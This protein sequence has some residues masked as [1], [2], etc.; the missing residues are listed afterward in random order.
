MHSFILRKKPVVNF[1][2]RYFFC[3]F[4]V[5][6]IYL[7]SIQF[8][9]KFSKPS[10]KSL[11]PIFISDI[12][13]SDRVNTVNVIEDTL[14]RD[15]VWSFGNIE[16]ICA[17][18]AECIQDNIENSNK[19]QS[20]VGDTIFNH[21]YLD[22]GNMETST[23]DDCNK[24][25]LKG[26]SKDYRSMVDASQRLRLIMFITTAFSY[27]IAKSNKFEYIDLSFL[28][29]QNGEY[30]LTEVGDD[31][32]KIFYDK[33]ENTPISSLS[34]EIKPKEALKSKYFKDENSERDYFAVFSLVVDII[35]ESIVGT[36]D[37]KDS[38][39]IFLN[40]VYLYHEEIDEE[41]KFNR[42]VDRNKKGTP[43]SD[44]SMYP[45]YIIN[46]YNEEEKEKVFRTF[47][48]FK[49]I[50][51]E[52]QSVK[53]FRKTKGGVGALLYIM[54][55]AL[56]IKI[57]E[58]SLINSSIELKKVFSSTFNLSDSEYGIDKCF[59]KG[60]VFRTSEDAIKYFE[61]CIS[62][63]KFLI[64]DSFTNHNDLT[65]DFYYF[66]DFAKEDLMWWYFIKP[67]YITY[68]RFPSNEKKVIFIKNLLF[69]LYE[70]YIVHRS[71][72]S[73]SQNLINLLEKL[74]STF[75]TYNVSDEEFEKT[76]KTLVMSYIENAGGWDGLIATVDSLN[77]VIQS[78]KN[79]IENIFIAFEYD[80]CEKCN[81]STDTF[82]TLWKRKP[83]KSY[84]IDHWFPENKF[85]ELDDKII[86]NS[87]GNLVL[88]ESS[89]NKSKQDRNEVNSRYY[90][91]SKYTQTLLMN[92]D[93]RG[94]YDNKKLDNITKNEYFYRTDEDT[95]NNP[96]LEDIRERKLKYSNFF[97]NFIRDFIEE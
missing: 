91:Q 69:R 66:R 63:A 3:I 95:L 29:T 75:L 81:L 73:N 93:N 58:E 56:K 82:Y 89:L 21:S 65:K 50:A 33:V 92:K 71:C 13:T 7:K 31:K 14:Q 20:V 77:Y 11:D 1:E 64:N 19:K 44:E 16:T 18:I 39:K 80:L 52:T 40:N 87:I 62:I 23:V 41:C 25:Y 83:N 86:F 51:K 57:G 26:S 54:I 42:F 12:I 35:E 49:K 30:K 53:L 79:A 85:K 78:H 15:L 90:T 55:E 72:D 59:K 9:L 46:Q 10:G 6:I 47:Q 27:E 45:T 5:I 88:L 97:V 28:K 60:I 22:L 70:F 34:Q 76:C 74:S 94:V 38:F 17:D 61:E 68:S 32:L 84:N 4:V 67:C 96:T 2:N 37:I 36:Y 48:E 8:M 43:M 24:K